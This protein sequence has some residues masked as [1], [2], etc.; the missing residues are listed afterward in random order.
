MPGSQPRVSLRSTQAPER[1][2]YS[3]RCRTLET[4]T[5]AALRVGEAE[6]AGVQAQARVGGQGLFV[7]IQAV[8]EQ[9]VADGK[10]MHA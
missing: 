4:Q 9:R 6:H 3:E 2:G 1:V 10:H 5:L 7:G 8:T